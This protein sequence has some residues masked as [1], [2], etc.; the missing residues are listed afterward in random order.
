MQRCVI[1]YLVM[2]ES[3]IIQNKL[4]VVGTPIGNL[5]D[6]SERAVQILGAV[7]IIMCEDTRTSGRM[8][9][10]F[11]IKTKLMAFHQHN[12]HNKVHD[13]CA[14]IDGGQSVALISD[15]GM[16]AISDPGFLLTRLAH[17][18]GIAVEA[19]PGPTALITALA[20]SGLP[21]DRFIFEG[22]LPQ[23]KGRKTR[24]EA[25]INEERTLVF[26]ESPHRIIRFLKEINEYFGSDRLIA[27]CRELTKKFEEITRG[28]VHE[29][30]KDYESRNAIKGEFVVIVS[31][32][33][34]T[35]EQPSE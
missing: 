16:P 2:K 19:I 15:A 33:N 28:S 17:Q 27:V 14:L 12:E 6:I 22:F 8:L 29:I 11:G 20:A 13:V 30:L 10:S 31:G 9:S 34:Y 18:K 1:Q 35:E 23:K 4:Y 32:C 26:Y 21:S 3:E 7:D 24:I 25:L 5:G